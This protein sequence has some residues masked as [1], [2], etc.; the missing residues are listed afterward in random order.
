MT[1]AELHELA[2]VAHEALYRGDDGYLSVGTDE[3][4]EECIVPRADRSP[5]QR[6][7]LDGVKMAAGFE[8][9]RRERLRLSSRR[10]RNAPPPRATA[11][12]RSSAGRARPRERHAR[13]TRRRACSGARSADDPPDPAPPLGRYRR[14]AA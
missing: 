7:W 13:P 11:P 2:D 3:Y 9:R 10:L 12:A 6:Q 5:E 4:G 8:L 14:R 1:V